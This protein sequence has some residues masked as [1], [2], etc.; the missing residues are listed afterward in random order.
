MLTLYRYLLCSSSSTRLGGELGAA[1]LLELR[2]DRALV[3]LRAGLLNQQPP[4]QPL[5][6][7][8]RKQV[9]RREHRAAF[10]GDS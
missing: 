9:L 8:L 1:L 4:R 2:E 3:V 6:V 7:E 5:P 10:D